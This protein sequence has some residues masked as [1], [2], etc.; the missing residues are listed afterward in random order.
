VINREFVNQ[1]MELFSLPVSAVCLAGQLAPARV[2]RW[3]RGRR[4]LP[5]EI[6]AKIDLGLW[7]AGEIARDARFPVNWSAPEMSV[8]VEAYRTKLLD[9][10]V[11]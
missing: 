7:L 10:Q 5:T 8:I 9:D 2:R 11:G 6:L 3:L 4:N 1:K